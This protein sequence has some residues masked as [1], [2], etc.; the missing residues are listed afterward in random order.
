MPT[1][2]TDILRAPIDSP[3]VLALS[4]TYILAE[5]PRIYDARIIQSISRGIRSAVAHRAVGYSVPSWVGYLS[6]PVWL[7]V[8]GLFVLNW[9]YALCFYAVMFLLK[10]IPVLEHIGEFLMRPF[11]IKEDDENEWRDF[12]PRRR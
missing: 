2:I 12:F 11:M 3:W 8:I 7:S 9:K 1:L 5:S 4:I 6:F 10:V